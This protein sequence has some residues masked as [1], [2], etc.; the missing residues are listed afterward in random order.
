MKTEVIS[1]KKSLSP[2]FRRAKPA[3][4][5]LE[6]FKKALSVLLKNINEAESEEFHKNEIK[7]FLEGTLDSSKYY[8]NTKGRTDLVVHNSKTPRS[9]AGV[10]IETKSPVNKQEMI[11]KNAINPKAFFEL[12]LYYL[13]ERITL[14]NLEIRHLIITN[15]HEWFIFDANQFERLFVENPTLT[16]QFS[17]FEDGR[18]SG[19]TTQ[20]FYQN[21]AKPII[22]KS[23]ETISF[24]WFDLQAYRVAAQKEG[25]SNDD[26]KII[27]LF[28]V[29]DP[30]NRVG[31]SEYI[32]G[33]GSK[34]SSSST[35]TRPTNF[36][37]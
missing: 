4:S 36:L 15:V 8:M 18:L 20:F 34:T 29:A 17:D 22:E 19:K 10:L 32:T 9:S 37:D 11:S 12:M 23:T 1:V 21:I 16:K 2:A 33:D 27:P 24:S 14:G 13:R 28:K 25:P 35:T 31:F 6:H 26:A 3:R 5:D 7:K 30:A